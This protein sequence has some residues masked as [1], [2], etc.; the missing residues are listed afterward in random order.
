M[1][2]EICGTCANRDESRESEYCKKCN[3]NET[4]SDC[5]REHPAV[6]VYREIE[7]AAATAQ[8]MQTNPST[9]LAY[10]R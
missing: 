2:V 9:I 5:Y 3:R 4:H 1:N 7:K 6:K 8:S 10:E